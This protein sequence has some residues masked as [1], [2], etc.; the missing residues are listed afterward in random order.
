MA[1]KVTDGVNGL[2]FMCGDVGSL[3][4]TIS[5][6][7]NTPGLWEALRDGIPPVFGMDEHVANLTDTYHELRAQ[8]ASEA[9]EAS[10][11]V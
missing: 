10:T 11:T 6:A 4:A 9:A 7:V 3:A 5:A 1:E 8:R 2:H